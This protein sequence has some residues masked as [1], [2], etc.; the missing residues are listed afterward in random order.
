MKKTRIML[1]CFFLFIGLAIGATNSEAYQ[2][3]SGSNSCSQC[4]SGFIGKGPSHTQHLKM[5]S[6]CTLCHIKNGD[7]PLIAKCA[8]CHAGPGLRAHHK[9]AGAPLDVTGL[10][11]A[12]CH[13]GDPTPDPESIL[14]PFYNRTDVKVNR[15]CQAQ[16]APPGEDFSGNGKGLDNDG[17]LLYDAADTDCA[18]T[19]T[20]TTTSVRPTTTTSVLPTTTTTS[21]RPTTTTSVLPTTTTTSVRPT[22]TTSVL[23]TTTTTSAR[24]TTTTSVLPTTTTRLFDQQ[25]LRQCCQLRQL[26][27]F[28]QQPLHQCCQLRLHVCSTNNHDISVA[29]YDNYVCLSQQPLHQYCQL[30][31]LRLYSQQLLRLYSQQ[32]QVRRR[33]P[34]QL[35]RIHPLHGIRIVTNV[36]LLPYVLATH[37]NCSSCHNGSPGPGTV[38]PSKCTALWRGLHYSQ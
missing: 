1:F 31:L 9:N 27:L 37:N 25:P 36:I 17:D 3:Y 11:C 5:T 7:N 20:T 22:T 38:L 35:C 30:Q 6:N 23:P 13:P 2:N 14:P 29:N 18:P 8:G 28:D 10:T 32:P 19:P 26:R 15:P 16:P 12:A 24:P 21:V 33:I 4:H 34:P